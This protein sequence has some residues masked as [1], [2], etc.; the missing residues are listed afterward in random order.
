MQAIAMFV[1]QIY[2]THR[3]GQPIAR[4]DLGA[5]VVGCVSMYSIPHADMKRTV[6]VMKVT[7]P[8]DAAQARPTPLIPELIDPQILT[9]GSDRGMMISGFEEIG[10]QRFYQGWWM[11]WVQAP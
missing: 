6:N 3:E 11:Q 8:M 5:G 2:R 10:K 9:F 1:C 4:G 7:G